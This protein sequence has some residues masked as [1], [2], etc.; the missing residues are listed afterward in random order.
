MEKKELVPPVKKGDI[1]TLG[2]LGI[3]ASGD[4]MFKIKGDK[5]DKKSF[6]LFLKNPKKKAIV[7]GQ[8][9]KLKVVKVWPKVGYVE[10]VE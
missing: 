8:Q 1:V 7:I 10:L 2:V 4:L 3:G 6:C 5:R 9:I